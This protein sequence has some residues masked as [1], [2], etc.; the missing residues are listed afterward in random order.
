MSEA[1]KA[2]TSQ[3]PREDQEGTRERGCSSPWSAGKPEG[4]EAGGAGRREDRKGL[5][6]DK[7]DRQEGRRGREAEA[8]GSAGKPEGQGSR[9]S[10]EAEAGAGGV[11]VGVCDWQVWLVNAGGRCGCSVRCGMAGQQR[12]GPEGGACKDPVVLFQDLPLHTCEY[13]V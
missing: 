5:A 8:A 3:P 2:A 11:A 7:S 13:V 12:H 6:R 1:R 4:R 9:R 10:K